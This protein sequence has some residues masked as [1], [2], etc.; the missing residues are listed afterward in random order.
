MM[1]AFD[2][3]YDTRNDIPPEP[4]FVNDEE[5][6]DINN[7]SGDF[8][9]IFG[10]EK[11]GKSMI[12]VVVNCQSL[13]DPGRRRSFAAA[14]SRIGPDM[15]IVTETWWKPSLTNAE[16]NYSF[17]NSYVVAARCDRQHDK[18]I[19]N[20]PGYGGVAILLRPDMVY[21]NVRSVHIDKFVQVTALKLHNIDIIAVYN[22]KGAKLAQATHKKLLRYIRKQH[23]NRMLVCGD[24]NLPKMNFDDLAATITHNNV[25][26]KPTTFQLYKDCFR[27]CG[28]EQKVKEATHKAG[29]ILDLVL[30][31]NDDLL[32]GDP[33]VC[34][35][36]M[37][38]DHNIVVGHLNYEFKRV[39]KIVWIWDRKHADLKLYRMA[40]NRH[41]LFNQMVKCKDVD[42]MCE[43]LVRRIYFAR[44]LAY[45]KKRIVI[46]PKR[47]AWTSPNIQKLFTKQKK[48]LVKFNQWQKCPNSYCRQ[49][50]GCKNN[51]IC[52]HQK[53]SQKIFNYLK[54][55]SKD[56]SR[57]TRESLYARQANMVAN[58][59]RNIV[60]FAKFMRQLRNEAISIGP[61]RDENGDLIYG[62]KE[63]AQLLQRTYINKLNPMDTEKVSWEPRQGDLNR[64][65]Y[66]ERR[67]RQSILDQN[68]DSA[69]G[70]IVDKIPVNCFQT[71][72]LF[73]LS[74][75]RWDTSILLG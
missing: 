13:F 50:R 75:N 35:N 21:T 53:S 30:S 33:K 58:L 44:E 1:G 62:D 51:P 6:E 5:F 40:L 61:L 37:N 7:D 54:T 43:C 31:N 10:M 11:H 60:P 71:V 36:T 68:A 73:D 12:F 14:M 34:D 45:P 47:P 70:N 17:D 20:L 65:E 72:A 4:S 27:H 25:P 56:I 48:A 22:A 18:P 59:P 46:N 19:K 49:T 52:R 69:P 29:N 66:T 41:E 39:T 8:F 9:R 74:R 26:I 16:I 24:F 67:V 42:S 57:C 2:L 23:S 28:L 32:V 3:T 38:S 15:I 64:I 63:K 55:L